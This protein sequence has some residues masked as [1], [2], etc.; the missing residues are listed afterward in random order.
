M[1]NIHLLIKIALFHLRVRK[2]SIGQTRTTGAEP[3]IWLQSG[4]IEQLDILSMMVF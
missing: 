1:I 2:L 3:S 4:P